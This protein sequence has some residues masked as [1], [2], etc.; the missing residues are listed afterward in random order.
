LTALSSSAELNRAQLTTIQGFR[1]PQ[2]MCVLVSP[3]G[4][5][6]PLKRYQP[7]FGG[8]KFHAG[9]GACASSLQTHLQTAEQHHRFRSYRFDA[10]EPRS[11]GQQAKQEEDSPL[12]PRLTSAR[13]ELATGLT[14][15][16]ACRLLSS[17]GSQQAGASRLFGLGL[18]VRRPTL[19]PCTSRHQ[20]ECT[21]KITSARPPK[22]EKSLKTKSTTPQ[23]FFFSLLEIFQNYF[24]TSL[25]PFPLI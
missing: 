25:L 18:P 5:G 14:P 13:V 2:I 11:L 7:A 9:K 17:L 3:A 16:L 1:A 24:S 21:R 12:G 20:R 22:P 15:F 19:F 8:F 23:I 10:P 4:K 6:R